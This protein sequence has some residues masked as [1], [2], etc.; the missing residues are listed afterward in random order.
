MPNEKYKYERVTFRYNGRQYE[1]TGKTK[2][3]AIAK[4]ERKKI[5]LETAMKTSGGNMSVKQWAVEWL[6]NFKAPAVGEGQY[7][8]YVSLINSI[9]VPAVGARRISDIKDIDL[10]KI[11]NSQAGK[12]KSYVSKLRFTLKSMFK[13]ARISRMI[14]YDPAENLIMPAASDGSYRS[15]T[16]EERKYILKLVETH[17]AGLWIETILYCGLRPGET[18]A[19]DWKH[20]DFDKKRIYVKR[21]MKAKTTRIDAP[22]SPS[23]VREIPLPDILSNKLQKFQGKPNEPVFRQ[24]TTGKR[25]TKSS[26]QCY[27]GNFKRELDI[28]MGA[29]LYRN[30]IIESKVAPDLVPYCLRH[31]YGTDLQDMGV[32]L[33]IAKYLMGHSDI[34]MTA[35]IYTHTTETAIEDAAQK[36]NGYRN[37]KTTTNDEPE[38]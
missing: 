13:Q 23:G 5:A 6:E 20:I 7:L 15:I 32:L 27:W 12:S 22:K 2:K 21:A 26:M 9:I 8:N 18:R 38:T 28:L 34:A 14:Q 37:P 1:A 11:L 4:A 19:L 25:H 36:I 16:D 29:K 24:P 35:N 33:N 3:E 30:Q 17:Y 10:Q 31:T